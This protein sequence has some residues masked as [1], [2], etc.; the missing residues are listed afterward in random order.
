MAIFEICRIKDRLSEAKNPATII[1]IISLFPLI[2]FTVMSL[3]GSISYP[4]WVNLAYVGIAILLGNEM[5]LR[6]NKRSLYSI[7]L[8]LSFNF[9]G[10]FFVGFP[11][12]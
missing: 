7:D 9:A 6:L 10:F 12:L 2:F 1:L 4:H 3:K 11:I 8:F 5:F